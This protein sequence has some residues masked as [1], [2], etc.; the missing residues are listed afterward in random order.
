MFC[1]LNGHLVANDIQ[2]RNQHLTVCHFNLIYKSYP[3]LK[4]FRKIEC[5]HFTVAKASQEINVILTRF[6]YDSAELHLLNVL[7]NQHQVLKL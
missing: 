7:F 5:I 4:C 2:F 3:A 6:T 1:N